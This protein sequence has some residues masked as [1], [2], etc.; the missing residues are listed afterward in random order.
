MTL[1][2]CPF[3]GKP[4]ILR[5]SDN[6]DGGPYYYVACANMNCGCNTFG[7]PTKEEAIEKWNR[8]AH[9]S[10]KDTAES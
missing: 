3:C 2:P 10:T 5:G 9:E 8:R 4:G 6:V 7:K 1:K